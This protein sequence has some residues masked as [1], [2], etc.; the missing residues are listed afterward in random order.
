L[1][2]RPSIVEVGKLHVEIERGGSTVEP[3][4]IYIRAI[5]LEL[6][7]P[8]VEAVLVVIAIDASISSHIL[9]MLFQRVER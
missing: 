6:H 3:A 9:G 2:A 5:L 8:M 1:L 7:K 4:I